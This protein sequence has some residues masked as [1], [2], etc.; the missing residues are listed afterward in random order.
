MLTFAKKYEDNKFSQFG[1]DGILK[2]ILSRLNIVTGKCCEFGAHDGKFCSNTRRLILDGWSAKLIECDPN[3]F[4]RLVKLYKQPTH[5]NPSG[6]GIRTVPIRNDVVLNNR[7]VT[8][9]NVNELVPQDLDVLSIDVDGIDYWLWDQYTG[10][11]AVVII[12]INSSLDPLSQVAGDPQHG[13]SYAAM[14]R[15]AVSKGYFLVCHTGNMIFV[16]WKYFDLFP[17][18]KN[19]ETNDPYHPIKDMNLFFNISW[20]K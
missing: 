6:E 17:E 12:E 4:D 10:K 16:D 11:P 19:Q 5:L 8:M 18:L 3:L 1:E 20:Q 2:E 15:L 14:W 7:A 13:S 9:D